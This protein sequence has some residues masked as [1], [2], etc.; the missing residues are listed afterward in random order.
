MTH[1]PEAGRK[2]RVAIE[3]YAMKQVSGRDVDVLNAVLECFVPE[4]ECQKEV[5][6]LL[7]DMVF[8]YLLAAGRLHATSDETGTVDERLDRFLTR[9]TRLTGQTLACEGGGCG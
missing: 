7:I 9:H 4:E 6:S 2:L 8:R 1:D 5:R 3:T